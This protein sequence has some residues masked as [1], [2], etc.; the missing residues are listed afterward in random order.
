MKLEAISDRYTLVDGETWVKE[1]LWVTQNNP[2][3]FMTIFDW[4]YDYNQVVGKI[5]NGEGVDKLNW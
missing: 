4:N 3:C 2:Y 1:A 5:S